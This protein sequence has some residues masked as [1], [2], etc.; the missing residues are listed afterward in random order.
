M[1]DYV[2]YD[3]YT[4][5][6]MFRYEVYKHPNGMYEVCVQSREAEDFAVNE[7]YLYCDIP[8]E[9]THFTDTRKS[10]RNRRLQAVQSKC[11]INSRLS[12][13]KQF[14]KIHGRMTVC[15]MQALSPD[16]FYLYKILYCRLFHPV[17]WR[18]GFIDIV[19]VAVD[20]NYAREIFNL[21]S[22]NS[23]CA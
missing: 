14:N 17:F 18:F 22:A 11:L 13:Q 1:R 19:A 5:D 20:C 7:Q 21:I 12:L 6:R 2:I 4:D 15:Q 16:R 23:L 9:V 3:M 8:E 10:Y